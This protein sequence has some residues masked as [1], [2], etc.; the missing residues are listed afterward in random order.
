[1]SRL[2]IFPSSVV[3][4][5]FY[6]TLVVFVP[7]RWF[8][9]RCF[10]WKSQNH[11]RSE[12]WSWGRKKRQERQVTGSCDWLQIVVTGCKQVKMAADRR[13]WLQTGENGYIPERLYQ[14]VHLGNCNAFVGSDN[15]SDHPIDTHANLRLP[16]D[17]G[18]SLAYSLIKTLWSNMGGARWPIESEMSNCINLKSGW[19]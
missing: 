5:F 7:F 15:F 2:E 1:M 18:P 12:K 6:F 13:D 9:A 8:L 4:V 19:S 16:L 10:R 3:S 14:W 11:R 17:T